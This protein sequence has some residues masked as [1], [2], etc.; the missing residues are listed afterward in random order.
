MVRSFT[1]AT[2]LEHAQRNHRQDRRHNLNA[3]VKGKERC[4]LQIHPDDAET[5][6]IA[7]G[8]M[9]QLLRSEGRGGALILQRTVLNS[10]L[11]EHSC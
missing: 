9:V 3:L 7:Q 8:Y 1:S 4:T 6:G 2:R 10:V 5:L 11:L